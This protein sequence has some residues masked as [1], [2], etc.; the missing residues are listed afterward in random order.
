MQTLWEKNYNELPAGVYS[1]YVRKHH[2]PDWFM[3]RAHPSRGDWCWEFK[4]KDQNE[5]IAK[6][7]AF[8]RGEKDDEIYTSS[9]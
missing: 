4:S 7:E 8:A 9:Y 5:C 6:A 3:F 2:W 1:A